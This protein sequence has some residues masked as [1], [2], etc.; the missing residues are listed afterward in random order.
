MNTE[1]GRRTPWSSSDAGRE[2][3]IASPGRG[4]SAPA[5]ADRAP[6]A[7]WRTPRYE[8]A[9]DRTPG[10]GYGRERGGI[11]AV[12]RGSRG[13]PGPSA[14][15]AAPRGWGMSAPSSSA[16]PAA[17]APR[18]RGAEGGS[19][20]APGGPARGNAPA[21]VAVPRGGERHP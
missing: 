2:P 5:P 4:W 17:P 18:A 9:P 15:T 1:P 8:T 6:G 7:L 21:G 20:V 12:P 16:A 11:Y 13:G 19:R 3:M 14:P 10:G